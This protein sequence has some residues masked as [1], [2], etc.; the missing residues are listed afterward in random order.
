MNERPHDHAKMVQQRRREFINF[1]KRVVEIMELA[2]LAVGNQEL[3]DFY[4]FCFRVNPDKQGEDVEVYYE[5]RLVLRARLSKQGDQLY[6]YDSDLDWQL[7]AKQFSTSEKARVAVEGH[8][9]NRKSQAHL[10]A[11]E[12]DDLRRIRESRERERRFSGR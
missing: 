6:F 5:G 8:F 1:A 4:G 10:A 2:G 7:N 3:D 12:R 11:E 9:A